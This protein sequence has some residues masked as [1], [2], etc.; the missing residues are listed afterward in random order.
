MID[1]ASLLLKKQMDS[2]R[3]K[4]SIWEELKHSLL[5]F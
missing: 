1:V 2:V 5:H 3:M 4:I